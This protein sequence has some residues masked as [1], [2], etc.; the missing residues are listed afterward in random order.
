LGIL[1]EKSFLRYTRSKLHLV[2]G[3]PKLDENMLFGFVLT[4]PGV[5]IIII[6]LIF[7]SENN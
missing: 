4:P 1:A 5:Y 2:D 7:L 6:Q 3:T